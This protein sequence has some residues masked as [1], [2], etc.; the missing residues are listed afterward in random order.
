MTSPVPVPT[1]PRAW[2]LA[3][4]QGFKR[5]NEPLEESDPSFDALLA[6]ADKRI[7]GVISPA[8]SD[9]DIPDRNR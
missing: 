7:V 3:F 2:L 9:S 5:S 4:K 8:Q 1:N 6:E